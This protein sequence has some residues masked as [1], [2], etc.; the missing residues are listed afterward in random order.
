MWWLSGIFRE[1]TLLCRPAGGIDDVFVHAGYDHR[2]G[3]RHAA[4]GIERPGAGRRARAGPR[5]SATG[6]SR[7]RRRRASRGRP[8]CR[9]CTTPTVATAAETVRLRDRLPHGRDR[10]RRAHGQRPAGAVQRR[11]PA[12]VRPR[13]R[14][15]RHRGGHAG[16]RAADE[17]AQHQRGPDQPLPARTRTSSTCAT[18]TGC[19]SSTSATWRPTGS[20]TRRAGGGNPADGPALARDDA[21]RP[22]AP[23]G[24]AG[25]EPPERSSSGRWATR[26]APVE[27]LGAMAD[28]ARGRDPSRPLHY[29]RD[30]TARVR[31]RLL[32]HVHDPCRG[33]A[34]RPAAEDRRSTIPRWM[35]AAAG[36]R[37][38]CASTP[39]RW[40]TG[41]AG[42]AEYQRAVR[43]VPALPG[44]V[45]LG[46]DRPRPAHAI[47]RGRRVLRLRRR[48]RRAGPRRELRGRRSAVPG[49]FAVARPA[50]VQEGDRA[51]SAAG[52]RTASAEGREPL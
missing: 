3:Q 43:D 35:P 50:R 32:A 10:R 2:T 25:Q 33:R 40:A 1:V 11:Q 49:S 28:W 48:L 30:W 14:P 16:R 18:S 4:G 7:R 17:A 21:G 13:P 8:R 51:G 37:S 15:G 26:A 34:D 38:S 31:R 20:C 41:R 23:D 27:N 19:T 39:T 5:R 42:C 47:G 29:E 52:R 9:A 44:R 22:D 24:G 6:T 36:C 12:R 46:V 45:R